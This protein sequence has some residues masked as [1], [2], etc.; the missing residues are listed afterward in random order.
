MSRHESENPRDRLEEAA[1]ELREHR[2]RP[3]EE[4]VNRIERLAERR[5][6]RRRP[7]RPR[8]TRR[9]M[10][11]A[12]AAALAL[13]IMGAVLIGELGQPSS[14]TAALK[15]AKPMHGPVH[16][17]PKMVN[18]KVGASTTERRFSLDA[19][20]EKA[21]RPAR[22]ST[23]SGGAANK[24]YTQGVSAKPANKAS[25]QALT[26]A[27]S[28]AAPMT[29]GNRLAEL[30][31]VL[32]LKVGRNKLSSA[33]KKAE[34]I[35]RSLG[36][37]FA[38]GRYSVPSHGVATSRLKLK[39]PAQK[40]QDALA[41]ISAL[42]EILSQKVSFEDLQTAVNNEGDQIKTLTQRID[43]L[44]TA[45][46]DPSLTPAA[47]SQLQV[48]LAN[49]RAQRYSLRAQRN[50]KVRRGRMATIT[51]TLTT[52]NLPK[53][54]AKPSRLHKAIIK[55]WNGLCSELSWGAIGV[56]V[57]SP[58][59]ALALIGVPATRFRRRREERRLLEK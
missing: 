11:L 10:V 59:L 48:E 43:Q 5:S 12:L 9:R 13:A 30:R 34:E 41:R 55:A 7:A 52:G 44:V 14:K 23:A 37:Y 28:S 51:L 50:E 35:A 26:P 1:R 57:A 18:A 3:S 21:A 27:A 58:F 4:L 19:N 42:G 53:P 32:P 24:E 38:T 36:G 33:T 56:I 25:L 16:V 20:A 49:A 29:V 40:A 15:P 46:E 8:L 39:V 45:L 17:N 54:A 6:P 2:P 47:R 31:A 22:P